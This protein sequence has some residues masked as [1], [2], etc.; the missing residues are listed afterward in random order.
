MHGI[1]LDRLQVLQLA[2]HV[3]HLAEELLK[4]PYMYCTWPKNRLDRAEHVGAP[5]ASLC[6]SLCIVRPG[7]TSA[8]GLNALI[9]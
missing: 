4:W 3:L 1:A 9:V 8:D 7:A 6:F 5:I 2:L